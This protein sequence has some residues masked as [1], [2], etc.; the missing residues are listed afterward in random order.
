MDM[1]IRV[2]CSVQY[3][4]SLSVRSFFT[5]LKW[6][7]LISSYLVYDCVGDSYEMLMLNM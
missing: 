6:I 5:M 1:F 3:H 2:D 4:H 7:G